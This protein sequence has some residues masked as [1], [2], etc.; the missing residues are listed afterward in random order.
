MPDRS[1]D[2]RSAD[3]AIVGAGPAGIAAA[4]RAAQRGRSV[5]V[6]DE[7]P[8]PGGQIWR[9]S[10]RST[11]PRLARRWLE[12]LDRSGAA[13]V[14][15]ATVIDAE[16]DLR[17]TVEHR[18]GSF[19]LD[20]GAI[21]LATGARERFVPFPGWTLPGVVGVGG[22]QALLKSGAD[23]R[24]RT[25]V[26]AGSG[27]LLLPVAAAL[28]GAGARVT[29]VAEQARRRRLA[30]FAAGLWRSPARLMQAAH[31]RAGFV[32]ARYTTDAWVVRATGDD[33]VRD[34]VVQ[35]RRGARS[36]P[37]D[38]LCTGHGL[39][40]STEL[41]RLL[42]AALD[43]GAVAIDGE[44]QTTVL[45]VFA[46]GEPTGVAGVE[47]ALVQGQIAGVTATGGAPGR[48]LLM[49]R[50]RHRRY[51]RDL[52]TAFALRSE[53]RALPD[54]ETLVCRCEDVTFARCAEHPSLRAAK[55]HTH[56]GM[57]PCQGRVCGPA[58]T[59]LFGWSADSVRVPV[60][61]ARV[62]ALL[63]PHAA[64]AA[65]GGPSW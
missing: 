2:L 5:V 22:A 36:L 26:V 31:Y 52:E 14:T 18:T 50:D 48:A 53:L 7:N 34:V 33:R 57:G 45:G 20:P 44:Q 24:D 39:V 3:I 46:A 15:G 10:R 56:A 60:T 40:P 49:A 38:L 13:L 28:A 29:L 12:A 61:P 65:Q 27:P 16:P 58:L 54:A 64:S 6:L 11:L 55:L 19:V 23:V 63:E 35:D 8:R 21:I 42:G 9:H 43:G 32:R 4:V 62:S 30:R 17:L 59:F 51:A 41:A 25:A 37:C 47:S 1:H